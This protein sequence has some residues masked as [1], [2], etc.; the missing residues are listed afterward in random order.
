MSWQNLN[1][2]QTK[3]FKMYP[4]MIYQNR[5]FLSLNW[6]V[7]CE[8]HWSWCV[9][10]VQQEWPEQR[11]PYQ[12]CVYVV[13]Q[14]WSDQC[15]PSRCIYVVQQDWREQCH[16]YSQCVYVIWVKVAMFAGSV[17]SAKAKVIICKDEHGRTHSRTQH[18]SLPRAQKLGSGNCRGKYNWIYRVNPFSH[19]M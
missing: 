1:I 10:V 3:H 11:H 9:Y 6:H 14:D 7:T 5:F 16:P 12:R 8:K 4:S 2:K 13:Q 15:H 19:A 17:A 18:A